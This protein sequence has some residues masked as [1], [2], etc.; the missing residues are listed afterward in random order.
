MHPRFT[1]T[2]LFVF[3]PARGTAGNAAPRCLFPCRGA[4]WPPL[5]PVQPPGRDRCPL[6]VPQGTVLCTRRGACAVFQGTQPAVLCGVRCSRAHSLRCGAGCVSCCAV[7]NGTQPAARCQPGPVCGCAIAHFLRCGGQGAGFRWLTGVGARRCL[8][9]RGVPHTPT[10]TAGRRRRKRAEGAEQPPAPAP[11]RIALIPPMQYGQY[12]TAPRPALPRTG[13][14]RYV[15]ARPHRVRG[16]VCGGACVCIQRCSPRRRAILPCLARSLF[17]RGQGLSWKLRR[18]QAGVPRPCCGALCRGTARCVPPGCT[19]RADKGQG[20]QRCLRGR[21]L[22]QRTEWSRAPRP[23]WH[24][25]AERKVTLTARPPPPSHPQLPAAMEMG[26]RR[27]LW[28]GAPG[29]YRLQRERGRRPSAWRCILVPCETRALWH[30]PQGSSERSLWSPVQAGSGV[31]PGKGSSTL[32]WLVDE[33]GAMRQARKQ[34]QA[35]KGWLH[36]KEKDENDREIYWAFCNSIPA[37]RQGAALQ[38]EE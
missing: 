12:S 36:V 34:K 31:S 9:R 17:V 25:L 20:R 10:H 15:T 37:V 8:L 5:R 1:S 28:F 19:G 29:V 30:L 2:H 7:C 24:P 26:R 23:A 3:T 38:P 21:G 11:E 22:S 35:W 18:A 14:C 32:T 4:R 6:G 16:C 33:V 13:T 27:G